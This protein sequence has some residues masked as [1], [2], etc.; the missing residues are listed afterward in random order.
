[1]RDGDRGEHFSHS[2][3][4]QML[5][6]RGLQAGVQ[7]VT[8]HRFRH[9]FADKWLELG[10]NIDDLMNVAGWKSVTMPPMYA[11]GRGSSG[12]L[13]LTP[14]CHPVTTCNTR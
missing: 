9:T 11:R 1:M 8:P 4:R 13:R 2:G 12:R 6:R 5:E 10:G 3:V 7:H 14:G